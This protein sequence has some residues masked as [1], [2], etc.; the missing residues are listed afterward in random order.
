MRLNIYTT[1]SLTIPRSRRKIVVV[2]KSAG[3]IDWTN[4]FHGRIQAS[5]VKT[6]LPQLLDD[7]KR[8]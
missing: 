7:V 5:E 2:E 4:W 3:R 6:Q 8:G 1:H